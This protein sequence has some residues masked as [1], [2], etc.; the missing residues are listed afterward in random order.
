MNAKLSFQLKRCTSRLELTA[1]MRANQHIAVL[2]MSFCGS[3]VL[4]LCLGSLPGCATIGE[5]HWLIDQ[6]PSGKM[7]PCQACG[8][9]CTHLSA[10]SKQKLAHCDAY[11]ETIRASL[12]ARVLISSDKNLKIY[13]RLSPGRNFSA[14]VLFKDPIY[15]LNSWRKAMIRNNR[16]HQCEKFLNTY[17]NYYN[18]LIDERIVGQKYY[19][20]TNY[21]QKE[22]SDSLTKICAFFNISFNPA[23]LR[24]WEHE[25]HAIGGSFDLAYKLA[26][27][28]AAAMA[29]RDMRPARFDD[30]LVELCANHQP[31][32][33]VYARLLALSR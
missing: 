26:G 7:V 19:L 3:T 12:G 24:Y 15:Q 20:Y 28:G 27:E 8:S 13:D 14:I 11:Y 9:E 10:E 33:E 30:E 5:S 1:P 22:P 17:T 4:S 25:H 23:A 2:G 29:V 16:S 21:F 6:H 18:K 31:S 32:R